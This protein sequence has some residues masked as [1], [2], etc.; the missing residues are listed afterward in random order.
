MPK[1]TNKVI[2]SIELRG[3]AFE[4]RGYSV[5]AA[6]GA[7]E[8]DPETCPDWT[9]ASSGPDETLGDKAQRL[10]RRHERGTIIN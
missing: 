10:M 9:T 2:I 4:D 5:C 6:C 3:P 7:S 1:N 8:C